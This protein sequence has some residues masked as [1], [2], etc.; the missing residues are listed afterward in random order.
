MHFLITA[1]PTREPIDAVRFVS[2]RSSGQTGMALCRA[3]ID[4]GHAVTLLMGPGPAD[5]ACPVG[6]KLRRF[7]TVAELQGQLDQ[8]IDACDVLLM[9]A[10]VSDH[11]P[12]HTASGKLPRLEDGAL[13]IEMEPT[14]DLVAQVAQ[15]T[16]DQQTI[17]AFALEEADQLETRATRKLGSKGVDVIVA[18]PLSSMES[19]TTRA[20][21]IDRLGGRDVIDATDKPSFARWLIQRIDTFVQSSI[22]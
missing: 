18:N 5:Q 10:A 3:A 15:N 7:E 20:I 21:W 22:Q 19:D 2:N 12:K 1:G 9:A 16:S 4:A 14:P 6:C 11:R 8:H 17:V 13:K